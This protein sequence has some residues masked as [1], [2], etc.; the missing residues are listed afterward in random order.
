MGNSL[1][2]LRLCFPSVKGEG[3]TK[4]FFQ[5]YMKLLGSSEVAWD[6]GR[7]R[8][9][10]LLWGLS[11]EAAAPGGPGLGWGRDYSTLEFSLS[12]CTRV[13]GGVCGRHDRAGGGLLRRGVRARLC[14]SGQ[15]RDGEH[16]APVAFLSLPLLS[17]GL[18]VNVLEPG[19]GSMLLTGLGEDQAAEFREAPHPLLAHFQWGPC[20]CDLYFL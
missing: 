6:Q 13:L 8:G 18:G 16:P 3:G 7:K 15:H 12:L 9:S 4:W 1:P 2:P 10:L 11:P 19:F 5:P 17:L 14:P 20:T